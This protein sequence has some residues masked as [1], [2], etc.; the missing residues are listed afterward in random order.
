MVIAKNNSTKK[1]LEI[2]R[3]FLIYKIIKL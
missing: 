2:S 3:A 1:A